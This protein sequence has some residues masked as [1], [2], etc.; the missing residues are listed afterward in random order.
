[1]FPKYSIALLCFFFFSKTISAQELFVYTEPA[2]NMAM[3]S[4]GIRVANNFMRVSP[5]DQYQY[6]L[7]PEIMVG[8]SKKLML[9]AETFFS[10]QLN[11]FRFNGAALYGKYRFYSEDEVHSHFRMAAYGRIAV[12]NSIVA[13]PAV[14]LNGQNSGYEAGVVATKLINKTAIS[15]SAGFVQAMNNTGTKKFVFETPLKNQHAAGYSLS[16]GQLVL[17]KEY[18]SYEQTNMNL[19]LEVLGQTNLSSGKS[20]I[21]LAPSV[22]FILLS[23]M[24]L[25]LGYRFPVVKD[26]YR[27]SNDGFLVRLEY[28][29]FNAYK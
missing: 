8:V 4:I 12:N 3:K 21:D 9:H 2:S 5:T 10:N 19:M 16:I 20:Y 25:D 22:Q 6:R 23:K 1:M 7:V 29:I 15:A 11:I 13:S 18:T 27:M 24:R 14:D 26:L 28:N 17:P